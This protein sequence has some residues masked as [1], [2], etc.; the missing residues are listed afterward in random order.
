MILLNVE[1][2]RAFIIKSVYY[3]IVFA[4]VYLIYRFSIGYLLPFIISFTLVFILRKPSL[5][6]AEK[7]GIK[8]KYVS[9]ILVLLTFSVAFFL[10]GMLIFFIVRKA[11]VNSIITN[12]MN[13]VSNFTADMSSVFL[14]FENYL[15]KN[16]L[17]AFDRFVSDIPTNIGGA[18]TDWLSLVLPNIIS[19][20]PKF[21]L[22]VIVA[23][24]AGCYFSNEYEP[25]K[26]FFLSVVP[27]DKILV[28]KKAKSVLNKNIFKI[29]KG[30]AIISFV[31]FLLC[32]CG[33]L[34][35][36]NKNAFWIAGIIALVDMLPVL[37]AGTVL[38][39]WS[40]VLALSGKIFLCSVLLLV[41]LCT[42]MIHHTL[43]PRFVGRSVGV[44]PLISLIVMFISLKLFGFIGMI[45]S[46]LSLITVINMYKTEEEQM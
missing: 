12:T 33:L 32:F 44:P 21:L 23:I 29:L 28:I 40:I 16:V 41:Y 7:L 22:S 27:S 17:T 10:I 13:M 2:K 39:P 46:V 5:L 38:I 26:H 1:K 45:V 25:L 34:I 8:V 30:Y 31:I 18:L 19:G 15:P 4:A 14:K 24:A 42:M 35:I 3:L 43:E 37:G 36:G 11:D 20:I 6:L 9:I